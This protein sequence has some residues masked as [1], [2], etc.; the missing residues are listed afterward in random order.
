MKDHCSAY[1]VIVTN[2]HLCYDSGPNIVIRAA[3]L[4]EV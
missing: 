2:V 3:K 4:M 1:L